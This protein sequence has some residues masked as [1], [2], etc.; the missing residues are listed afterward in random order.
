MLLSAYVQILLQLGY[1]IAA[2]RPRPGGRRAVRV[3]YSPGIKEADTVCLLENLAWARWTWHAAMPPGRLRS[4]PLIYAVLA[5]NAL[6][7]LWELLTPELRA[8]LDRTKTAFFACENTRIFEDTPARLG[9]PEEYIH[10]S[11]VENHTFWLPQDE[12]DRVQWYALQCNH[13]QV[14]ELVTSKRYFSTH[15]LGKRRSVRC[16]YPL[17]TREELHRL[18]MHGLGKLFLKI[19]LTVSAA[20]LSLAFV[21]WRVRETRF[22]DDPNY[23]WLEVPKIQITVTEVVKDGSGRSRT[24][25]LDDSKDWSWPDPLIGGATYH[26]SVSNSDRHP[27]HVTSRL[28]RAQV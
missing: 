23:W 7:F 16:K 2:I 10:N 18:V 22:R 19:S 14:V 12:V 5:H 3:I 6:D 9:F 24:L 17:M 15:L 8:Q 1:E 21:I 13:D 4:D 27:I 28:V 20:V 25:S 11:P 26:I